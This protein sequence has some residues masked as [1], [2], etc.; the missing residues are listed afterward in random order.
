MDSTRRVSVSS[1][2]VCLLLLGS[3][4]SG[5]SCKCK[6]EP[7]QDTDQDT[8][9]EVQ[10]ISVPLQVVSIEPSQVHAQKRLNALVF[11]AAFE[12]GA[13]VQV[14]PVSANSVKVEDETVL[15]IQ[16]EG[17]DVGTYDVVV[18]N[19][20]GQSSTLRQGVLVTSEVREECTFL[21]V[22]FGFDKSQLDVGSRA[23]LDNNMS[24]FQATSAKIRIEGHT[25]ERGTVDYNLSLGQRRAETV[26]RY[27]DASG[28]ADYRMSTVSYGKE[29]PADSAHSESAWAKNRRA[30]IHA[31]R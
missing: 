20:N 7:P 6:G 29:R 22:Y 10:D 17:L 28:I 8:D 19:P 26:R 31:N 18:T 30:D 21:Q 4:L 15:A 13:T 11:G 23:D 16:V 14:G 5:G 27:F 9:G 24:C 2:L 12:V 1:G 3:V 25:D